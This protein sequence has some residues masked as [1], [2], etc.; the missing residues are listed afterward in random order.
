ME[1]ADS[2]GEI[3]STDIM[4]WMKVKSCAVLSRK[5]WDFGARPSP[6]AWKGNYPFSI[7][8]IIPMVLWYANGGNPESGE[9]LTSWE[10]L[11][12]MNG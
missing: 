2:E 9:V 6:W 3:V 8:R 12:N 7:H 1:R 11:P 5:L 10:G 4:R